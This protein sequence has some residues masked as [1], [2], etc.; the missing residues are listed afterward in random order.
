MPHGGAAP[1]P[2]QRASVQLGGN[3]RRQCNTQNRQLSRGRRPRGAIPS[4]QHGV[5]AALAPLN[6]LTPRRDWVGVERAPRFEGALGWHAARSGAAHHAAPLAFCMPGTCACPGAI[7]ELVGIT[8][9]GVEADMYQAGRNI[10]N[11]ATFMQHIKIWR[12]G[13]HARHPAPPRGKRCRSNSR[14]SGPWFKRA[15]H[16]VAKDGPIVRKAIL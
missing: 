13:G 5:L 12:E 3:Q 16:T 14:V 8:T 11:N 6:E 7:R 15:L 9:N 2:A 10:F 4:K 1:H